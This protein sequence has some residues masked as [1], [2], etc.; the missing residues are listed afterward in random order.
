MGATAAYRNADT[1]P[2]EVDVHA[3]KN[4]DAALEAEAHTVNAQIYH[5][6]L[7]AA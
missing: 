5:T 6:G 1:G 4:L 7:Q 3:R 2:R